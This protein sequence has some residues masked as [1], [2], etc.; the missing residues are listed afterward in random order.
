MM[1]EAIHEMATRWLQ[2]ILFL[3]F[4]HPSFR[5]CP[6]SRQEEDLILQLCKN[7]LERWWWRWI[8]QFS[9]ITATQK[10]EFALFCDRNDVRAKGL[11]MAIMEVVRC[12]GDNKV[13]DGILSGLAQ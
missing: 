5:G 2:T 1:I 4:K 8:P 11:I 10:Q 12:V 3:S 6:F 13:P 7:V 9:G